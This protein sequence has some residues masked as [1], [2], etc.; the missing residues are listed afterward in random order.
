MTAELRGLLALDCV[1]KGKIGMLHAVNLLTSADWN[2][3]KNSC[4]RLYS[5]TNYYSNTILTKQ[6]PLD[7]S[8][9]IPYSNQ[10]PR[11]AAMA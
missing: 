1:S 11:C 3:Y 8:A 9:S 2:E 10:S 6:K 4:Q 7:L 5:R